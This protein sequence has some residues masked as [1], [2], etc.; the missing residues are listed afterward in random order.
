M[1]LFSRSKSNLLKPAW[2]FNA[3]A[4]K[5]IWRLLISPTGVL[6]G[7][8]RDPENK[9]S[10]L[11]ALDVPT[12]NVLWRDI[13]IDE[14]WWFHTALMTAENI[15]VHRFRKPDMPEPLGIIALDAADGSL[16]WEQ[17]DVAML[18]EYGGK[19]Y[20]Q[21]DALGRKEFF[22]LDS[23]TG[24]VLE[25]FGSEK[26]NILSLESLAHSDDTH[27]VYS[28]P[29]RPDDEIFGEISNVL[30][31][32]MNVR[33]LRGA[34]DFTEFGSNLVMSYHERITNNA[35]AALGNLLSNHLT[36]LAKES[37]EVIYQDIL[38]KQ[39]PYP[40]G[41]NFFIHRGILIYVKETTEIVGIALE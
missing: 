24:E 13:N 1:G 10:S 35:E 27:S 2:R 22:S 15:Y 17:P 36:I 38:N 21:R 32:V 11:F 31:D 33:E 41:D 14:P 20:A 19:V 28:L 39:T 34:I 9:T 8:E 12:G 6:A 16:R 5:I 26:E 37:G 30:T 23:K 18:F 29:I 7:E 4:G 3:R 40:V 25:A